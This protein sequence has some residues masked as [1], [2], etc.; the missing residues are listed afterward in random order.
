ML[1]LYI[2]IMIVLE[3]LTVL[4]HD[5]LGRKSRDMLSLLDNGRHR[6]DRHRGNIINV[7]QD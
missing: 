1:L 2:V 5:N 4:K 3:A 6:S 7:C